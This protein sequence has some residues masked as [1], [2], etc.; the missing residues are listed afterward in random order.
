[1]TR[2]EITEK[3]NEIF[4]EIDSLAKQRQDTKLHNKRLQMACLTPN[5]TKVEAL[6]RTIRILEI[7]V[8]K[9]KNLL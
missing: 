1:M 3:M 4:E 2:K 5:Y 6:S 9:L 8:E 7:R